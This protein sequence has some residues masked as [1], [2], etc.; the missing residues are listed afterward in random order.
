MLVVGL[1]AL[2]KRA[3]KAAQWQGTGGKGL[4]S[5]PLP[6]AQPTVTENSVINP[7]PKRSCSSSSK[8]GFPE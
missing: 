5:A 6:P 4:L 7:A 2:W 3:S 8:D 1:S